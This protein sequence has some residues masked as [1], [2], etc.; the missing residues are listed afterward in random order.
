MARELQIVPTAGVVVFDD[1]GCVLL[2]KHLE[3]SSHLMDVY[4]LPSGRIKKGETSMDTAIRELR[5][6]TGLKVNIE[7]LSFVKQYSADIQRKNG[8]V[9]RF[10]MDVYM[11][12]KCIGKLISSEETEPQ[13][14]KIKELGSMQNLLPNTQRAISDS[15]KAGVNP[16]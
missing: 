16:L 2:V 3:G 6:E 5:E 14:V 13:W 10:S 9:K 12:I 7:D 4:G 8:F 15:L 11:C 1:E